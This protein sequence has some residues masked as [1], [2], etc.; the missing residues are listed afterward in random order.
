MIGCA[1]LAGMEKV[2]KALDP[3][4]LSG[5]ESLELFYGVP[6]HRAAGGGGQGPVRPADGG[7]PGLVLGRA[8]LALSSHGRGHRLLR[9]PR[10][11]PAGCGRG[12]EG[13]AGH[14]GQVPGWIAHRAPGHRGDFGGGGRFLL[15][16]GAVGAGRARVL[17]G[18]ATGRSPGAGRGH[19]RRRASAPGPPPQTLPA[20]GRRGGS[21]PLLRQPHRRSRGGIDGRHRASPPGPVPAG[22]RVRQGQAPAAGLRCGGGGRR[23][24]GDGPRR[25]RLGAR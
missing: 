14:G 13:V 3:E 9:P 17:R 6:P 1:V 10:P 25:V 11:R 2:L 18:A 23:P 21:L 24:G 15:G 16:G 7:H 22:G 20:L 5:P 19:R 12:H 4:A 8:P